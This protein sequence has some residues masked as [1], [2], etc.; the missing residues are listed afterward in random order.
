M[1]KHN[2]PSSTKS[3]RTPTPTCTASSNG[4]IN[5]NKAATPLGRQ[6]SPAPLLPWGGGVSPAGCPPSPWSTSGG[7]AGGA[8]DAGGADT[9]QGQLSPSPE[10]PNEHASVNGGNSPHHPS[11][12]R[13][14][15][16]S[17][18]SVVA[19]NR[20]G[21]G[22]G[23][24]DV[25]FLGQPQGPWSVAASRAQGGVGVGGSGA[26]GLGGR[27]IMG[28]GGGDAG[29]P[30][31]RGLPPAGGGSGTGAS[32][33]RP[34]VVGMSEIEKLDLVAME[35][36]ASPGSE[37]GDD[38]EGGVLGGREGGKGS[39]TEQLLAEAF[40]T[41]RCGESGGRGGYALASAIVV[42]RE[43]FEVRPSCSIPCVRN[44]LGTAAFVFV[45]V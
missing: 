27:D 2:A 37:D 43:R 11:S 32:G 16:V 44:T 18:F 26:S 42:H 17:S 22:G 28:G 34:D 35:E 12:S 25:A 41:L 39:S 5:I 33:S 4:N 13:S 45:C 36:A 23:A 21:G 29:S 10:T 3:T 20:G 15:N 14:D 1:G 9:W 7:G 40:S 24:G 31:G 6:E 8:G 38:G 19:H 30:W